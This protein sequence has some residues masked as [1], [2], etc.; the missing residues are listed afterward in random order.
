MLNTA[1]INDARVMSKGQ[2]TIPKN[3]RSIL[4]IVPGDRV[5]FV[6]EKDSVRV[7]NSVLYA[8]QQ[9]QNDMKGQAEAVGLKSEDDVADWIT[10]SR[11]MEENV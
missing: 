9:F 4:G 10:Q 7:V 3:I 5:T 6:A 2:V 1:V 11:R 8:V